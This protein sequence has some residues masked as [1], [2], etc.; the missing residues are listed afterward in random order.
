MFVKGDSKIIDL[1]QNEFKFNFKDLEL[2]GFL[3]L[4]YNDYIFYKNKNNLF[5]FDT[6]NNTINSIIE[7]IN[8]VGEDKLFLKIMCNN[9]TYS[10]NYNKK[11]C[12]ND[13]IYEIRVDDFKKKKFKTKK[14]I[15]ID[16]IEMVMIEL[17]GFFIN[18][19]E[20]LGTN[21]VFIEK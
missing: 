11:M 14:R 3:N 21:K 6:F 1:I 16:D 12:I 10:F 18:D 4:T 19:D 9:K 20:I 2:V 15:K 7:T 13:T 5:I 17:G 8:Y